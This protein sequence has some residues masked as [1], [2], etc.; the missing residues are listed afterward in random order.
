MLVKAQIEND[1]TRT[2]PRTLQGLRACDADEAVALKAYKVG[3]WRKFLRAAWLFAAAVGAYAVIA[4]DAKAEVEVT[5]EKRLGS[6]VSVHAVTLKDGTKCAVAE[7]HK[8]VSITCN[9]RKDAKDNK[10]NTKETWGGDNRSLKL[11]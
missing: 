7:S 9:W 10:S 1:T 2:F 3:K 4:S 6:D 8:G 11:L 5:I